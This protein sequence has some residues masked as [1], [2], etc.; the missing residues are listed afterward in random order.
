MKGTLCSSSGGLGCW[1]QG[2]R[3]ACPERPV[4][5]PR[6][7]RPAWP[8]A[9]HYV[10]FPFPWPFPQCAE[11]GQ[12]SLGGRGA[13]ISTSLEEYSS[14]LRCKCLF[15]SLCY[16]FEGSHWASVCEGPLSIK[17]YMA[18]KYKQTSL[19]CCQQS[20]I[21]PG[22]EGA[23]AKPRDPPFSKHI[24]V[25]TRELFWKGSWG[26]QMRRHFRKVF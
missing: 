21:S 20:F 22:L 3:N 9:W 4:W 16:D 14:V 13:F 17:A 5:F 12:G 7:T 15:A 11:P 26:L 1:R 6:L 18:F 23:R 10:L 25:K 19:S 8:L 2:W 24:A